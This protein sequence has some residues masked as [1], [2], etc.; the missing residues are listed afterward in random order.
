MPFGLDVKSLVIGLVIG[1]VVLP[2]I[3]TKMRIRKV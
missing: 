2:M 1:A 3:Q